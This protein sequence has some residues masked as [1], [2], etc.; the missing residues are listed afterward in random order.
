MLY[1][2]KLKIYYALYDMTYINFIVFDLTGM[3]ENIITQLIVD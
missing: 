1:W 2:F 3:I